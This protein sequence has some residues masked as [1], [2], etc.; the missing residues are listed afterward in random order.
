MN[1]IKPGVKTSEFWT[2]V[3]V[4]IFAFITPIITE[5]LESSA[6]PWALIASSVIV[7]I[8]TGLY[9]YNRGQVK[10][11]N[12]DE[13][14]RGMVQGAL[15]AALQPTTPL[16]VEQ[17]QPG[18]AATGGDPDAFGVHQHP[19]TSTGGNGQPRPPG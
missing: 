10:K 7:A 18:N 8:N 2:M 16:S 1:E 6:A 15:A 12:T 4:N 9:H 11:G 17:T 14:L 13:A 5:K 3:V 19:P